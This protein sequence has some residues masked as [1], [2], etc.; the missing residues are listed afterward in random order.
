MAKI[1]LIEDNEM[2]L[3]MLSRRL[4][5]QGYDVIVALDGA[6]GISMAASEQ[7]DLILMDM[8]LPIVDG[9]EATQTLKASDRTRAIPIIALTAHAMSGD[10][11]KALATGC[12]DYDT[13]P[14]DL[15]R[16]VQKIEMHLARN[17][18]P[19]DFPL[20]TDFPT[21]MP[22]PQGVKPPT[23]V[24][25]PAP[26]PQRSF[27]VPKIIETRTPKFPNVKL[28]DR[29]KPKPPLKVP[30]NPRI[31]QPQA[32]P[33]K[34]QLDNADQQSQTTDED[35]RRQTAAVSKQQLEVSP[36]AESSAVTPAKRRAA[37]PAEVQTSKRQHSAADPSKTSLEDHSL[38]TEV[39]SSTCLEDY[40]QITQVLVNEP[41]IRTMIARD[42]QSTNQPLRLLKQFHFEIEDPGY[43]D[44]IRQLFAAEIKQIKL[45]E[46][47][48][49]IAPLLN[50]FNQDQD[51][52][53]VHTYIEGTSLSDELNEDNPMA[54]FEA[55]KLVQ[56]LLSILRLFHQRPIIHAD[57]HPQNI[58]RRKQDGR[59]VFTDLGI[60]KRLLIQLGQHSP[61]HFKALLSP[62]GY[63]AP[64]HSIGRPILASDIYSVGIIGLQALTGKKPQYLLNPITGEFRWRNYVRVDKSIAHFFEAMVNQNNIMRY[65]SA[66]EALYEV[67]SLLRT[68]Y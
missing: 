11:E 4:R 46:W 10:K 48:D 15:K 47:S 45:L 12:D 2:N 8:S 62:Q 14:V 43:L 51:F 27:P 26:L 42:F 64:E 19:Q 38:A 13:K 57:I 30:P 25:K 39:S 24:S 16:L 60:A 29:L 36:A 31:Q 52:Y 67:T 3:D 56:E 35:R 65:S 59:L 21:T 54:V 32:L 58:T 34:M 6:E 22:K 37:N 18:Q 17:S 66:S 40:Y 41:F 28:P 63:I 20:K 23:D 7:P 68:L 9:W 44:R 33:Q 55:L 49:Q 50:S 5:R 53:L 1:L 61:Q